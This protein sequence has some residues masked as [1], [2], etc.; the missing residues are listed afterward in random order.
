MEQRHKR[1]FNELEKAN[2]NELAA[3]NN[4]MDQRIHEIN[5]EGNK[6]ESDMLARH[7]Q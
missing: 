4:L 2:Q 6:A 3:F 5:Q 1:E 7:K